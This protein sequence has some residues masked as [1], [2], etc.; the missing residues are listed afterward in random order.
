VEFFAVIDGEAL[1]ITIRAESGRKYLSAGG[2]PVALFRLPEMLSE[3]ALG[4]EV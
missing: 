2:D 4:W 3:R 1:P